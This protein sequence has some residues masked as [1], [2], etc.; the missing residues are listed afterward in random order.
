M[1]PVGGT[2]QVVAANTLAPPVLRC[3][4][5][6]FLGLED[7]LVHHLTLR[8]KPNRCSS[9]TR[10]FT[11]VEL[12]VVIAI[13]AILLG[14]LL[15]ALSGTRNSARVASTRALM[16]SIDTGIKSFRSEKGRLPG[17]FS[18]DELGDPR[19]GTSSRNNPSI[20][21]MENAL[22][23]L[24]GG[25]IDDAA[26]GS[27][28]ITLGEGTGHVVWIQPGLVG[29]K[30]GPE[31]LSIGKSLRAAANQFGQNF[32]SVDHAIPD[33]MDPFGQPIAMWARNEY[34]GRD[35][36]FAGRF[37]L[38]PPAKA[39]QFYWGSNASYMKSQALGVGE[40]NQLGRS[41]LSDGLP[42]DDLIRSVTAVCGNPAFPNQSG[43]TIDTDT[44]APAA[45]RGDVVLHSAGIDQYFLDRGLGKSGGVSELQAV[46]YLGGRIPSELDL[47]DADNSW[48]T[49][50]SFD[51][52]IV[53]GG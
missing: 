11:L 41:L 6:P 46:W 31:Y 48:T 37:H 49:I 39:A 52:I 44:F 53:G 34:A 28:S 7:T 14:L 24:A 5:F 16:T 20:T 38:P 50:D 3:C 12:L 22:L 10:G 18:A 47:T 21:P 51:D 30:G 9:P 2:A 26:F 43:A 25:V 32:G 23:E 15:P 29:A 8:A 42:V 1:T 19:N 27:F 4:S 36:D 35:A 17:A 13:I 40:V 45:A 33:V